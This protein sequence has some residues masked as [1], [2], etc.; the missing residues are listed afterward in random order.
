MSTVNELMEN[1]EDLQKDLQSKGKMCAH[2]MSGIKT[3]GH[4]ER[5]EHYRDFFK[6]NTLGMSL[7]QGKIMVLRQQLSKM[8]NK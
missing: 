5:A 1:L 3:A 7:I 4:A 6:Y 2:C 8:M